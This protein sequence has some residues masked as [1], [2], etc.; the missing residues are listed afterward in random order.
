MQH[1]ARTN[2]RRDIGI[3]QPGLASFKDA[4]AHARVFGEP[5]CEDESGCAAADDHVVIL[6][7]FGELEEGAD[8]G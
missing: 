5:R 8:E 2:G 1:L 7:F 3:S 4:N 6:G